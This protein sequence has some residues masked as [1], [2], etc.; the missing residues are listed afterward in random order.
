M[1]HVNMFSMSRTQTDAARRGATPKPA[2]V[3]AELPPDASA[4]KPAHELANAQAE[5]PRRRSFR[6]ISH[7]DRRQQRRE[8]LIAAGLEAFGTRG[9]HEVTVREICSGAKLTERY[10]YESFK[11]LEALFI[12]VY[13]ELNRQLREAT[14]AAL[15]AIRP[16]AGVEPL[17]TAA[18]RVLLEFIRDD[19][20]RARVILIDAVSI[21]HD[22]QRLSGEITR[23]Y[24]ALLRGFIDLLFPDAKKRGIP[25]EVI[26]AG[27]LGANIHIATHWV[28]ERFATPLEQV[29]EGNVLIYRALDAY[30]Q[31]EI[32]A[33]PSRRSAGGSVKP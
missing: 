13:A 5:T 26:A 32:A 1:I 25:V 18:V 2:D 27:L 12:A 6:G 30:W 16:P 28:R 24:A 20:R 7:E 14:L 11:S 15:A 9:Y 23:D 29:L 10:F 17:A 4:H 22:V 31:R 8:Q 19:P 3:P 33:P 21:S